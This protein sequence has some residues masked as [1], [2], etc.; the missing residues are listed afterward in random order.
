MFTEGLIHVDFVMISLTLTLTYGHVPLHP[1]HTQ[2]Q[3]RKDNQAQTW[4]EEHS[5]HGRTQPPLTQTPPWKT[6]LHKQVQR[7]RVG[8]TASFLNAGYF[9]AAAAGSTGTQQLLHWKTVTTARS[10]PQPEQ[11]RNEHLFVQGSPP[12][13]RD[14]RTH[15]AGSSRCSQPTPLAGGFSEPNARHE[16][17]K[18]TWLITY[19]LTA[20]H[21]CGVCQDILYIKKEKR[22]SH[23]NK[24][25]SLQ[26]TPLV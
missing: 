9:W 19:T 1:K 21:N 8:Q 22:N 5:T 12:Q 10:V 13:F 14:Q 18:T 6:A 4:Q 24:N 17:Q 25:W 26:E 16:Q 2:K 11:Q 23:E 20:A 7:P 15:N 3:N